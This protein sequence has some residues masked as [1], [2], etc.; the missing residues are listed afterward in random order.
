MLFRG[1]EAIDHFEWS[2]WMADNGCRPDSLNSAVVRGCYD[3]AFAN[4]GTES[5][6]GAGTASL[7]FLR[8]LLTYKGSIMYALTEPMGD[9]IIA[10]LYEYFAKWGVKF[11]FFCR[12]K[13]A[14]P[15][16]E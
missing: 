5:G 15:F 12:V 3:Y 1:F 4:G 10:P 7:L 16:T 9:S 11:E 2:E 14:V 13:S 6:I 8:L